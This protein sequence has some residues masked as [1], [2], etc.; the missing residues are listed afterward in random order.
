MVAARPS[1]NLQGIRRKG[2][3]IVQ[4]SSWDGYYVSIGAGRSG[5]GFDDTLT[6]EERGRGGSHHSSRSLSYPG[7][8]RQ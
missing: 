7:H 5:S 1:S 8:D 6:K 4:N 3:P 2:E